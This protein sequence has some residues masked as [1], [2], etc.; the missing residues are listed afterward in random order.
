MSRIYYLKV[1][2]KGLICRLWA[3]RA[4]MTVLRALRFT[5]SCPPI[6]NLNLAP[7][8]TF[9]KLA[10]NTSTPTAS[11]VF[12]HHCCKP[13]WLHCSLSSFSVIFDLP[14]NLSWFFTGH[15][16]TY[17]AC[18]TISSL[19]RSRLTQ[20]QFFPNPCGTIGRVMVNWFLLYF[21]IFNAWHSIW[22][23]E[24]KR[25]NKPCPRVLSA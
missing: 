1:R 7:F 5:F 8:E 25:L 22:H 9:W 2:G 17:S 12:L 24:D 16:S 11:S 10:S 21:W 13:R 18:S 4:E 6:Q 20:S 19:A 14:A 15:P 23:I 3:L